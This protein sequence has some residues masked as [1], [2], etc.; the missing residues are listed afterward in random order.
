MTTRQ[1]HCAEAL[2]WLAAHPAPAGA[3]VVTSLP[4][5]S[6]VPLDLAGWRAWFVAAVRAV[7][8]WVPEEGVAVF[9]QSDVRHGG[10]WV[11]KAHL[12]LTGADAEAATL[13]WHKIVCRRP[14]GT[15]APGRPSYSHMLCLSRRAR[16]PGARVGPDVL[17]DCGPMIWSRA[18][19]LTAC[20]VAC[21]YLRDEVGTRVVV[22]PF[23]GR[24]T[25]LA[26]ANELG[27]DAV[28]V[29]LGEK[30]CRL[31]RALALP[32]PTETRRRG[33]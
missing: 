21:Q 30:R 5:V 12:V 22:D 31:A 18:M 2:G 10:A 4:D 9:Y 16:S 13:V 17:S 28:G 3:S 33:R 14:P 25:V 11:D 15:V 26:V 23:C 6:E 8:R 27:M 29:D 24:G 7:V 1:V 32:L 20:R 19:G